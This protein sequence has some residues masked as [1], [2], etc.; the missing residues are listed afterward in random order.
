VCERVGTL[1]AS[2]ASVITRGGQ[3]GGGAHR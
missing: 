3:R 2:V 1:G